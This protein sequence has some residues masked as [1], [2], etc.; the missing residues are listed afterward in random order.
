MVEFRRKV[1]EKATLLG[2][3]GE[4]LFGCSGETLV[5][6]GIYISRSIPTKPFSFICKRTVWVP[7]SLAF[8]H[9]AA[10]LEVYGARLPFSVS[11]IAS[12]RRFGLCGLNPTRTIRARDTQFLLLA[13]F[14]TKR[15]TVYGV[16]VIKKFG[17][18]SQILI[19]S[20]TTNNTDVLNC[21]EW[22]K[23]ESTLYQLSRELKNKDASTNAQKEGSSEQDDQ[24]VEAEAVADCVPQ[25]PA[26]KGIQ[27]SVD[28]ESD[29]SVTTPEYLKM[30][31]IDSFDSPNLAPYGL[32]LPSTVYVVPSFPSQNTSEEIETSS[33][34]LLDNQ[35]DN[36]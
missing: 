4:L 3:C 13:R 2:Q 1:G 34:F 28:T 11:K 16:V 10:H 25:I 6:Q 26:Q 7:G 9:L 23:N 21:V 27:C 8:E 5:T 22:V 32:Y 17:P 18:K 14:P 29:L 24:P 36:I 12:L 33:P 35:S 30:S 31:Q 19:D 15:F 20:I